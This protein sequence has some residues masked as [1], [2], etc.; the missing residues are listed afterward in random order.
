[1]SFSLSFDYSQVRAGSTLGAVFALPA[2]LT[3][4]FVRKAGRPVR[5]NGVRAGL[6]TYDFVPLDEDASEF[7]SEQEAAWAVH[8]AGLGF[9]QVRILI[10][11]R[12]RGPSRTGQLAN[13][14]KGAVCV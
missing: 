10:R 4:F 3:C 8:Q 6:A 14:G 9:D 12:V 13:V 11:A 1:M 7:E 2:N 5:F